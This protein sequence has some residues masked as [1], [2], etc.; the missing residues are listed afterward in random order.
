MPVHERDKI[1]FQLFTTD[2]PPD[3]AFWT[4]SDKGAAL[5]LADK[6]YLRA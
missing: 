2:H 3:C 1:V 6:C 4:D 5:P